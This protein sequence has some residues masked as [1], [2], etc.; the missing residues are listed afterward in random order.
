MVTDKINDM[1]MKLGSQVTLRKTGTAKVDS[2]ISV[3]SVNS[4]ERKRVEQVMD[5]RQGDGR[6]P[7]T[8]GKLTDETM[9][10]PF[11]MAELRSAS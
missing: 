9:M 8:D 10:S 5:M 3:K 2:E 1:K 6:L 11:L 7:G 4:A